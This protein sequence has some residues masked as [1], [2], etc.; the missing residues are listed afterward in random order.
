MEK[1]DEF[2][3]FFERYF[4]FRKSRCE[5]TSQISFSLPVLKDEYL[6]NKTR[7]RETESVL[8]DTESRYTTLLYSCEV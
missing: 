4:L 8:I 3:C 7:Y 6:E 2:C 5:M 1:L